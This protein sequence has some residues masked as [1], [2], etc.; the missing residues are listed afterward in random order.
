MQTVSQGQVAELLKQFASGDLQKQT[1]IDQ[2]TGAGLTALVQATEPGTLVDPEIRVSDG[3]IVEGD[4]GE[5][6]MEFEVSLT[7]A[8]ER[9][10]S[11]RYET[12]D[13]NDATSGADFS[14]VVGELT[15]DVGD[16]GAKRVSVPVYGDSEF[17]GEEVFELWVHS[18]TNAVISQQ[19]G[20]GYIEDDDAFE[21]LVDE[22]GETIVDFLPNGRTI[23]LQNSREV[24]NEVLG[25]Q[26]TIS[27]ASVGGEKV[28]AR[29]NLEATREYSGRWLV[30]GN[31]ADSTLELQDALSMQVTYSSTQS[32][33]YVEID[34]LRI[35]YS[36]I[37][38]LASNWLRSIEAPTE[39]LEGDNI[40]LSLGGQASP[41]TTEAD[42]TWSVSDDQNFL[43]TAQGHVASFT[44]PNQGSYTASASQA[45]DNGP[46]VTY[47]SDF[48]AINVA[49]QVVDVT[50]P[51]EVVEEIDFQITG[52]IRDPGAND[53]VGLEIDWADGNSGDVSVQSLGDGFWSFVAA[54]NYA[55]GGPYSIR[56]RP[57]DEVESSEIVLETSVTQVND[58]PQAFDISQAIDED[59]PAA[60]IT[61]AF[62]DPDAGDQHTFN[63]N[64]TQTLGNVLNN[65][66]G[67]FTYN[68]VRAFER[69]GDGDTATD[70]FAYTVSD[71]LAES[72]PA[73]VT[74][75]ISGA[76]DAPVANAVN[77]SAVEDGDAVVVPLNASDVDNGDTLTYAI[78]SQP[79]EGAVTINNDGTFL[80]D[81]GDDFQDLAAGAIREVTFEYTAT[82]SQGAVSDPAVVTVTV[83]GVNDAP[84]V[85]VAAETITVR[86]GETA[87]NGVTFGDDDFGDVVELDASIGMIDDNEDG[88][89]SW[90]LATVDS[91]QS[92]T[93]TI[94]AT[95]RLGAS[96]ATTFGLDIINERPIITSLAGDATRENKSANGEISINGSF[97]DDGTGDSHTVIID[98]G[99]IDDDADNAEED[100]AEIEI[101]AGE[102]RV[103]SAEHSYATGGIFTVT[104]TV[105][106]DDGG[107]SEQATTQL[108]VSGVRLDPNTDQLQIVGTSGKDIVTAKLIG[109]GSDGDSDGGSAA[110]ATA[111]PISRE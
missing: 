29:F 100:R 23:L 64:T 106:D 55:E 65:S 67:T 104:V 105:I 83:T 103:F 43:V 89:W 68:P 50:L 77:A 5:V 30:Q 62:A 93:I 101:A 69:L 71:G 91:D 81:P 52:I 26:Q 86:E 87:E 42:L 60:I 92:Q 21:H 74:I 13:I 31:G 16:T 46:R 82:D 57:A 11:V 80:F 61:A 48:Q 66:D 1:L 110:A 8:T 33:R 79:D 7:H 35:E 15:W 98:W 88:T 38:S 108:W 18:P 3:R 111:V 49:P 85:G 54:Y 96:R 78:E 28:E 73:V 12:I 20:I 25:E 39:I 75:T 90:S 58:S 99:E 76:N 107:V 6:V 4:T 51:E 84:T 70:R 72:A 45:L 59:G 14:Q 2:A 94:T 9:E 47:E 40:T 97:R 27:I 10:V 63:I 37:D 44:V 32:L 34:G 109:G 41:P 95:D 56:L 53:P 24:F 22:G 36:G 17:E 19:I 102:D